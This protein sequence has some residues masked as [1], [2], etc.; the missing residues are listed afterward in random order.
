MFKA[1]SKILVVDDVKNMRNLVRKSLT[2][3]GFKTVVEAADGR[4]GW[5]HVSTS[6]EKFDIVISDWNMPNFS[7]IDLL[8]KIRADESIKKTPFLLLTGESEASRVIEA[9]KAGIDAYMVIPFTTRILR[10]K[11]EAVFKKCMSGE[12]PE[13]K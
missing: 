9:I 5:R 3:L 2:D 4:D 8:R 13:K 7:G 11:L 6:K 1:D 10:E 12:A